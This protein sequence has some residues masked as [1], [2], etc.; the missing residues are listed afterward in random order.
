M[1]GYVT[2]HTQDDFDAWLKAEGEK[3]SS[4]DAAWN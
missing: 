1:R 4:E 3:L 2:I